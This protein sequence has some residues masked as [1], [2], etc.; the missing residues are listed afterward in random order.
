LD[1]YDK[2]P[3]KTKLNISKRVISI[4]DDK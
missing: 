4:L 1:R 2:I 3:V